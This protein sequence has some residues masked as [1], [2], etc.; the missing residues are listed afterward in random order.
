MRCRSS[1][2][3]TGRRVYTVLQLRLHP[4]AARAS[5]NGCAQ[6]PAQRH[7]V[8]LTYITAR[9]RWYDVSWKGVEER[10]GG[11][12]T[13]IGIHFFDLLVW[14]FGPVQRVE[15]HLREAE[16]AAGSLEL[17]RA[18]VQLV[19]VG[20]GVATCR[21]RRSPACKTTFRSI[22]VDGD[23]IEF[24]EGFTDLHTRVYEEVLAGR[25][26]GIDEARPSIELSHRDPHAPITKAASADRMRAA[27]DAEGVRMSVSRT[28]CTS[29]RTSTTA[30]EIGAG[31]KIWHFSHVM[32]RR[33]IGERCNIGQ[34]VVISPERGDRQQ[35]QDPEQRFDLHRRV[36]RRRRVLRA[37]DGVHQRRQSAQP[38][39]AQARVSADAGRPRR[40]LG[41]NCTIVCGHDIGSL[42]S[43]APARS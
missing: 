29:R 36:A 18:D 38:C 30:A 28:S 39:R 12:V 35:R 34:N 17:E 25:G 7:E 16:R 1:S 31:T 27:R 24:S 11:I 20:R 13:N 6:A 40:H 26:F 21:S 37:V 23:E 41:A 2:D 22:T 10:S 14:L 43:S 9:G 8:Q 42:R 3:E 5:A 32:T 33:R 15:V 19:P 4:A